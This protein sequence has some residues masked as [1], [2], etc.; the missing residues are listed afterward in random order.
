MD[1]LILCK[2]DASLRKLHVFFAG[3]LFHAHSHS[4]VFIRLGEGHGDTTGMVFS[5]KRHNQITLKKPS[6]IEVGGVEMQ[7][8]QNHDDV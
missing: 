4:I 2:C 1:V 8:G 5:R 6:V 3:L 7:L